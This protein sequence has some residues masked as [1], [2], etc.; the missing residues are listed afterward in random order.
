MDGASLG[1]TPLEDVAIAPGV[2]EIAFVRDGERSAETVELRAGEH[3]RVAQSTTAGT[4]R[5]ASPPET[6]SGLDQ[7]AVQ[8]TIR[9]NS[10]E[11]RDDCWQRAVSARSPGAPTSA[12]VN[13]TIRVAPSGDVQSVDSAGVPSAY[14][15]LSGCI[16][17]K[18]SAWKFPSARGETVVNVPFVFVTD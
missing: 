11:V 7:A 13:V 14:P 1:R 2:H 15:Q 8:R 6:G 10:P 17:A 16:E 4:A 3:K 18:V 5:V 12:R 9:S